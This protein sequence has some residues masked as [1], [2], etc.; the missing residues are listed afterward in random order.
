MKPKP[1][2]RPESAGAGEGGRGRPVSVKPCGGH[3]AARKAGQGSGR[4][5]GAE[6]RRRDG[7]G[8]AVGR[9]GAP[10]SGRDGCRR[11]RRR[12]A[13]GLTAAG[14]SPTLVQ[15]RLRQRALA[16]G[17]AIA[18]GQLGACALALWHSACTQAL[19]PWALRVSLGSW[20]PHRCLVP[21]EPRCTPTGLTPS[22]QAC[23]PSSLLDPRACW[24]RLGG[25][26]SPAVAAAAAKRLLRLGL[27][28]LVSHS[29]KSLGR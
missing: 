2:G 18:A 5:E 1:L 24:A 7:V 14:G 3:S 25:S 21:N 10:L 23:Q 17:G 13:A 6:L 11:R 22:R 28:A 4:E 20:H 19:E 29:Q 16:A 15:A 26:A 27:G 9:L 12:V 8:G